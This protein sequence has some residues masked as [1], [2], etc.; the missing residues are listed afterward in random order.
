MRARRGT[1]HYCRDGGGKRKRADWTLLTLAFKT[2]GAR[3]G[4]IDADVE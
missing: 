3:R 2:L 4:G 1:I